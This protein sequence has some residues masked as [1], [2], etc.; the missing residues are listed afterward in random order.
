LKRKKSI[1]SHA[2][3]ISAWYAVFDWPSMVAALSRGR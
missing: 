2:A 3:S 1:A